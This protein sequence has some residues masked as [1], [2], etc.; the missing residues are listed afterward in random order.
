MRDLEEVVSGLKLQLDKRS[1]EVVRLERELT[2]ARTQSRD[3]LQEKTDG[4]CR[5]EAH[6][7]E[8]ERGNEEERGREKRRDEELRR[9]LE[10]SEGV[11]RSLLAQVER[12]GEELEKMTERLGTLQQREAE[13]ERCRAEASQ[14]HHLVRLVCLFPILY[15]DKK[16]L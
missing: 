16:C 13:A 9:S 8:L 14:L 15:S 2:S 3:L 12:N 1:D 7:R 11:R 5:L 6:L 10:Q 4:A